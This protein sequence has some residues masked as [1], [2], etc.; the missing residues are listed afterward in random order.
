M[1]SIGF[2]GG[3]RVARIIAAGWRR[4]GLQFETVLVHEPDDQA[5][6]AL[7]SLVPRS[8][9]VA[10]AEAATADRVILALHPPVFPAALPVVKASLRPN[11]VVVSL[12]PK[13][14]LEA[15]TAACGT[16]RLVRVIPNAPSVIGQGYNPMAFGPGCDAEAKDAVR[17][18][19]TPLGQAP[20]VAE[21]DLEAYAILSGMGPT[22]FWYQWQALRDVVRT[23]GLKDKAADEAL[24]AM[25]SGAMATLL[26]SGLSPDA[27]MD[28]VPVK[29][30][31]AHEAAMRAAYLE[32]LPALHAKIHPVPAVAG[33]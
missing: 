19:L 24:T 10:L 30:L 18:L 20:E 2:V 17:E 6:G 15:L 13:V 26:D 9:R 12:A 23:L 4:A 3:G 16:A 22:Y 25:V 8:R 29:P 31:A 27:V 5:I 21:T 32:A 7:R 11:A 1:P 14:T 28:L 33:H